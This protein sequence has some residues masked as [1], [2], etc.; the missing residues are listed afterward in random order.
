MEWEPSGRLPFQSL[1]RE[2]DLGC[3]GYKTDVDKKINLCYALCNDRGAS[4]QEYCTFSPR[5]AKP[6]KKGVDAEVYA[7]AGHMAGSA[8]NIRPVVAELRRAIIHTDTMCIGR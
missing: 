1:P 8:E 7:V 5:A 3:F 2:R 6:C 4:Y